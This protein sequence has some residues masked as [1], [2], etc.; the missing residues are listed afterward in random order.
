MH[1]IY[2]NLSVIYVALVTSLMA[3]L[4]GG[5]VSGL[6]VDTVPWLMLFMVEIILCFPQRRVG[7]TSVDARARVWRHLRHDPLVM[8]S[9]GLILLM[10]IPFV[11]TGLCSGCD[12][13]RI[14]RE[15]VSPEP[16]IRFLPFCVNRLDHLNVFLWVVTA[17]SCMIATKH[18][19]RR[20]GKRLLIEMIV[21]N[22]F[23]LA[24]LGFV[25]IAAGAPGPLW[26]KLSDGAARAG[27]YFATWGYPNMAGD[28]FTTLFGLSVGVWRYRYDV[29]REEVEAQHGANRPRTV[30]WR[31]N[32]YLI[33]A[34]VFF[35]AAQNTLSRAAILEVSILTVV[36]FLHTMLSFIARLR[37]VARVKVAGISVLVTGIVVFCAMTFIPDNVRREV[38]TLNTYETLDRVTGK[39]QYHTDVANRIWKQ[40]VLFGCG[41]WGYK[42]FCVPNMLPEERRRLQ[43]QGGI[44]VHNDYMQAL[45]EHGVVGLGALL[46]IVFMLLLPFVGMWRW[47]LK[48]IAFSKQKLN[49][50][51][52][53]K[54]FIVPAPVFCIL[55]T[56]LSTAIHAF[57]DC[58]FRSPA[59]LTLFFVSLA[60][61]YGYVPREAVVNA[62]NHS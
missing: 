47:M 38:D 50:A 32:L 30:F 42:H 4:F 5:T 26:T 46:T 3:W 28:Y 37:R 41:G 20:S 59:I 27:T 7:E 51:K 61:L 39:G 23:A 22:G 36:F 2:N 14:M 6:L 49:I 17:L 13:A 10:V 15:G 35:F 18:C 54:L 44:N 58:P 9:V 53:I 8:V 11:N 31:Q 29:V 57:G 24:I 40:H 34:V 56:V 12:F 52:P 1:Y 25:Q 16:P 60:A 55:M 43:T 48:S 62:V 19:L 21:W 45:A 33:P